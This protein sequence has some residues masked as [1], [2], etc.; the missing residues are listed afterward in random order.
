MTQSRVLITGD[1]HC[2]HDI[3]KLKKNLFP[4]GEK[5]SKNDI[6]IICG[7]AGFVWSGDERDNCWIE[8]ISKQ[9]WTT[10]YCDGN[11]EN[12]ALLKKYPVINYRGAK[13][14]KISCS[15][16]HVLR[17]EIMTI[18]DNKYF[19]FG[20]GFSHDIMYRT[21]NIS[22]WQDEL[23]VQEEVDNALN[24]LQKYDN[25]VDY[26][27]T[28]DVPSCINLI[29]GYDI[30]KMQNYDAG[31]IHICNFFEYLKD[32]IDFKI[33]F[34]GHYHINRRIESVQILY[35]DI[36]EVNDNG[37]ET[38]DN[39]IQQIKKAHFALDDIKRISEM[40]NLYINEQ[41]QIDKMYKILGRTVISF[42]DFL[43][44]YENTLT[45]MEIQIM[46]QQIKRYIIQSLR[47]N[48]YKY[49]KNNWIKKIKND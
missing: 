17:G 8:W 24:N 27:I 49:K 44:Q 4:Q 22:W 18:N 5:L 37:Y 12:H 25:K 32:V 45:D 38:I 13:V 19:F 34:A 9:P 42:S 15:L 7:D 33:W 39:P 23:P 28:H 30:P 35:D 41:L 31:Y 46:E 48:T 20:G 3:Y 29:L 21:E 26:I 14:H 36:V 11:H 40:D 43:K 2:P 6:L 16:Y 10:V 1:V 47:D